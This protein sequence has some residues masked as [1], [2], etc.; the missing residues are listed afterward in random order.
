M[1]YGKPLNSLGKRQCVG[2]MWGNQTC[3]FKEE[4]GDQE[5]MGV[6]LRERCCVFLARGR[7]DKGGQREELV[8][9]VWDIW[10]ENKQK[11]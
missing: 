6:G 8:T 3:I 9:E 1:S 5:Y 10:Q 11:L 4:S 2:V 7:L